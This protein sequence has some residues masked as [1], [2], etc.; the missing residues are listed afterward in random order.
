MKAQ[1]IAMDARVAHVRELKAENAHL[2]EELAAVRGELETVRRHFALALE[3]ARDAD[4]MPPGGSLMIVDGWNVL[5]GS[6]SL[7]DP[8]ERHAPPEDMQR[9]LRDCV[10]SWL[11][12]P[13]HANDS[14]WIVFDGS[15][16]GGTTEPRLRTSWTGGT[17]RHRADRLICDYLRMRQFAG[18]TMDVLLVTN[19]KDFRKEAEKLGARIS[20]TGELRWNNG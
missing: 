18:T 19:D 7:L 17:G 2:R 14:A 4:A 11:D 15:K 3:A 1:Q 9:K 16:A 8:A 13:D 5:L 6:D 20:G 12:R 10:R